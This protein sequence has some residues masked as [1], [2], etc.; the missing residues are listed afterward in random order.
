MFVISK[1]SPAGSIVG[2]AG[3]KDGKPFEDEKSANGYLMQL[4]DAG[5]IT[6]DAV[7]NQYSTLDRGGFIYLNLMEIGVLK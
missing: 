5:K 7:T 1:V 3:D 2:L 6:G 4:S